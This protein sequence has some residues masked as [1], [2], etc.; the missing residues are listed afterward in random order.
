MGVEKPPFE[1]LYQ[2]FGKYMMFHGLHELH[3]PTKTGSAFFQ[4]TQHIIFILLFCNILYA[5]AA[6]SLYA[7]LYLIDGHTETVEDFFFVTESMGA[8]MCCWIVIFK[9]LALGVFRER[10]VYVNERLGELYDQEHDE[11]E[12]K[13]IVDALTPASNVI[14]IYVYSW[15]A[16]TS[17]YNFLPLLIGLN[18]RY[19]RGDGNVYLPY[20][21][22]YPFDPNAVDTVYFVGLYFTH[23]MAGNC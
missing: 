22:S 18:A 13:L 19:M 4:Y 10:V 21:F 5:A 11:E 23:V 7:V 6:E 12:R 8:A 20:R 1:D 9:V 2:V 15:N 17:V 3:V 16:V 14:T